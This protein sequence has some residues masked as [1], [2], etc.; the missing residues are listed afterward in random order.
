[1]KCKHD[2]VCLISIW[3]TINQTYILS[4]FVFLFSDVTKMQSN[5]STSYVCADLILPLKIC[6]KLQQ[7]IDKKKQEIFHI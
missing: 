5:R 4:Q 6:G 1:M 3:E 2:V 7:I